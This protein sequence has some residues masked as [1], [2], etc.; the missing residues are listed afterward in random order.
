MEEKL[1]AARTDKL[2]AVADMQVRN[3]LLEKELV[4]RNE[5]AGLNGEAK[6]RLT[7][8]RERQNQRLAEAGRTIDFLRAEVRRLDEERIEL[9]ETYRKDM[10]RL[11]AERAASRFVRTAIERA[12]ELRKQRTNVRVTCALPS[13]VDS[14]FAQRSGLSNAAIFSL[15]GV[16]RV[17]G[18]VMS[19]E[20]VASCAYKAA[21]KGRAEIVPVSYTHLTLPT[22]A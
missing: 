8:D 22:K 17:G 5:Q 16:R 21:L 2:D 18:I 10:Q 1:V 11:T 4:V 13:A 6:E 9:R 7:R 14:E 19:A 15:P 20:A 12:A 3:V